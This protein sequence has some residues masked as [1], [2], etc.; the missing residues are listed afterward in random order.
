MLAASLRAGPGQGA[1]QSGSQPHVKQPA[2]CL[3][4]FL[5]KL[6]LDLLPQVLLDNLALAA[7]LK[8]TPVVV[9]NCTGFA[10]NRVFFPYTMAAIILADM[11]LNP[12]QVDA[13]IAGGFGMPMGPFR[14]VPGWLAQQHGP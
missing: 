9:G 2:L 3:T 12:Y 10:V 7:V 4:C 14:W 1:S 8:K 11:G 6:F 5:L 13:V